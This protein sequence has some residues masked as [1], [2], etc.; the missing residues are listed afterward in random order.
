MKKFAVLI[1]TLAILCSFPA[2]A[3]AEGPFLDNFK[4]LYTYMDGQFRDVQSADWFSDSVRSVYELGLM[5]GRGA[6]SFDPNGVTTVAEAI[7]LACRLHSIYHNGKDN[8]IMGTPWYRPY[9]AYAI[10]NGILQGDDIKDYTVP[11][12]RIFFAYV[13]YKALPAMLWTPINTVAQIPDVGTDQWFQPVL[14]ALYNAGVLSGSDQYGTFHPDSDIK[15]SEAAAII[16]RVVDVSKR[17]TIILA[18]KGRKPITGYRVERNDYSYYGGQHDLI[19]FFDT[20]IFDGDPNVVSTLNDMVVK[21]RNDVVIPLSDSD[22]YA[23]AYSGPY[24]Y[25]Y[26]LEPYEVINVYYDKKYVSIG[27]EWSWYQGGVNNSGYKEINVNLDTMESV[28]I[29]DILGLNASQLLKDAL[30][31]KMDQPVNID[32]CEKKVKTSDFYFDEQNV[33][34]TFS[35]YELGDYGWP[36]SLV[37][38]LER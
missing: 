5:Y 25:P 32:F 8:F 29:S 3:K 4:Q 2:A 14:L 18:E 22:K 37:V 10:Q 34:I 15:R 21:L 11:A 13:V 12:S 19:S 6:N 26:L 35:S 1:L 31:E 23:L 27:W 20:V 30:D 9:V 36:W 38:K 28:L 17:L 16:S 33:F 7:T 24:N